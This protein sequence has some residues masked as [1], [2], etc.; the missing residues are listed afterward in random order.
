MR[1]AATIV[2]RPFEPRDQ[3]AARSVILAGFLERFG[4]I[5]A[6]LNS[7]L[8]D[9]TASYDRGCFIVAECGGQLVATGAAMPESAG[10]ARISRMSTLARYR[11]RGIA[12]AVLRR[13][14]EHARGGGAMHIVLDTNADW[15]DAIACY[16]AFGFVIASRQRGGVQLALDLSRDKPQ[17]DVG[18]GASG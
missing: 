2:I 8:R 18:R 17:C 6:T 14:V 15:S 13:L 4:S 1:S 12:T 10:I 11:R 7:D 9:I 16:V 5:D 3:D